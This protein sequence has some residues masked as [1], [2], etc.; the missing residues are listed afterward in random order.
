[1][2]KDVIINMIDTVI[3]F[4]LKKFI[5]IGI[6]VPLVLIYKLIVFKRLKNGTATFF[7]FFYYTHANIA[8]THNRD[9]KKEKQLQNYLF[10]ILIVLLL[11]QLIISIPVLVVKN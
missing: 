8:T 4:L 5:I 2:G 11:L 1:M 9:R 10:F 7:D 6:L 3:H